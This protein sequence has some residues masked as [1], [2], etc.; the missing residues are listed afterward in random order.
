MPT[1]GRDSFLNYGDGPV[2]PLTVGQRV[3]FEVKVTAHHKGHFQ[4][5]LC[6]R[7]I[8][9]ALGGRAAEEAC[10]NEHVLQRVRPEDVHS[11]CQANDARG[12]CQP[13]DEDNPSYWYLPPASAGDAVLL[14]EAVP[15]QQDQAVLAQAQSHS[16]AVKVYRFYY[17]LPQGVTCEKCTLQWWWSSANSCTPHPDAYR[18][19]FQKMEMLGW[20][21]RSWCSGGCSYSGTCPASQGPARQC[22]EQFKNCADVKIQSGPSPVQPPESMTPPPSEETETPDPESEPESEQESEEE[23]PDFGGGDTQTLPPTASLS[24]TEAPLPPTAS[25]TTTPS[26]PD[27]GMRCTK[28]PGLNRGVSNR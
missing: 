5:R 24:T 4:F 14:E 26:S 28:T 18:C 10:L 8:S 19:Y 12:D 13:F 6:N 22:G 1:C 9:S 11:D 16:A 20:R 2:T 25:L 7:T 21:A 15:A 3:Q 17:Q 27:S 23:S